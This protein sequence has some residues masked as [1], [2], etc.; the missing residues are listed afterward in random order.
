MHKKQRQKEITKQLEYNFV[1]FFA[2]QDY[3]AP[4]LGKELYNHPQVRI[5]KYAFNGTK[6]EEGLFRFHY[7]YKV[8]KRINL[9]FKSVWFKRMYT[10]DFSNNLPICFV[11][12]GGNMLRFD[13]GFVDYIKQKDVRNK[14]VVIHW[15]LISKKIKYDYAL[16]QNKV[17]L[18]ITYD[19]KE[20]VK[21]G[22]HYFQE[23]YYSKQIEH[24]NND[25][26][27]D[28]YYLGSA[29]DRLDRIYEIFY[30]LVKHGVK[31]KF[32]IVGA[33]TKD[34]ISCEGIEF[35]KP[36]SYLDNIENVIKSK[37]ILDIS[38]KGSQDITLRM[39]EA[40]S[41][42]RRLITD[43]SADIGYLFNDGQLF[44]FTEVQSVNPELVKAE[45]P[46]GGYPAKIKSDPLQ[47]LY[48]IQ[49]KLR[50]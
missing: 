38:Q 2:T 29:K 21:Y 31:C 26:Q 32:Q 4:L 25:F 1:F 39:Q 30:H 41:Y 6:I 16:I 20:A 35:I 11:F 3:Y 7:A 8:N 37:C 34:Q 27:Q 48:F 13:S 44:Q 36:I 45:Y 42:E 14:V 9:P 23:R 24:N 46:V 19:K 12:I 47:R 22:I 28:V 10:Q 49:D 5:Y 17:D 40:I 18:A 50:K 15:D 43:C 33:Q